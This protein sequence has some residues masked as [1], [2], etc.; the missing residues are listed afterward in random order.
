MTA[1]DRSMPPVAVVVEDDPDVRELAGAVLE[2]SDLRVVETVSAEEALAYIKE[3]A[4]EVALIF[5]DVN[6]P[7]LMDGVDLARTARLRWPH[8]HV[9]L[10]SGDPA[11]SLAQ[12][13]RDAVFIPK[14]WRALDV[15]VQAERAVRG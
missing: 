7:C 3:H 13:P 1:Q 8:I 11:T 5:A 15:L 4:H 14:P 2:E 9:V 10:T 12:A 6:L